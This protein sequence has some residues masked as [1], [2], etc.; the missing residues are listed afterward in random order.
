MVA[1]S[2]SDLSKRLHDCGCP[3][4]AV[5]TVL[6]GPRPTDAI[7]YV[8]TFVHDFVHGDSGILV[9]AGGVGVGKTIASVHAI[10]TIPEPFGARRFRHVS[11]LCETGL[12]GGAEEKTERHLLK[13]CRVLVLDDLGTEHK[14]DIFQTIFDG[15]INA[16]YE[17]MGATIL[18]MNLTSDQFLE[19]YGQRVYDR[20]IGRGQWFDIAHPSLRGAPS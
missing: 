18:T 3:P 19:R 6:D 4:R 13:T 1:L 12:Y 17:S 9:L 15:L 11:E 8:T 10:A 20:I 2:T 5:R 14:T 7:Q 16:R